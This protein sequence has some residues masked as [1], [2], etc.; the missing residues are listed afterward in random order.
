MNSFSIRFLILLVAVIGL[1]ASGF[2]LAGTASLPQ[3]LSTMHLSVNGLTE[4]QQTALRQRLARAGAQF[5][6]RD[7][8]GAVSLTVS[9]KVLP[10][11]RLVS[12]ASNGKSVERVARSLDF[13]LKSADGVLLAPTKTLFQ[14]RD[15]QLDDDNLLAS[16]KEQRKVVED[17]EQDLFNQLVQQLIRI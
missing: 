6:K 7:D 11:R 14:Q 10:N 13:A 12:S 4:K 2:T 1:S 9:Y 3:E 5:V 17:L 8:A 15:I 16:D